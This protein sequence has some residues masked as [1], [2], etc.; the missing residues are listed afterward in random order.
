[1]LTCT[2]VSGSSDTN[3]LGP[4][5]TYIQNED[6]SYMGVVSIMSGCVHNYPKGNYFHGINALMAVKEDALVI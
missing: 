1:M 3:L 4:L 2:E 5:N 6:I